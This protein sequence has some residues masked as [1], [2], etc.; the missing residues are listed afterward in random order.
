MPTAIIG[1]AV[2]MVQ[3]SSVL[4]CQPRD[5]PVRQ[6]NYIP[7]VPYQYGS[8]KLGSIQEPTSRSAHDGHVRTFYTA[9]ILLLIL[10]LF[11]LDPFDF[12]G[13]EAA[14]AFAAAF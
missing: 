10:A 11:V 3:L 8:S 4:P 12:R 13:F 7:C 6:S 1:Q 14:A 5:R 2:G 9:V